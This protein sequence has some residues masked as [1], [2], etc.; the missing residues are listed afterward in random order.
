M[1]Q[2]NGMEFDCLIRLVSRLGEHSND[3][4]RDFL[5]TYISLAIYCGLQLQMR[6]EYN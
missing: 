1:N 4:L 2:S 5:G 6:I 3:V